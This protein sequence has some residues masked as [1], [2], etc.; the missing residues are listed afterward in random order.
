VRLLGLLYMI[1]G[2]LML[3]AVAYSFVNVATGQADR[4]LADIERQF[5]RQVDPRMREMLTWALDL[6]RA[7]WYMAV[8]HLVPFALG[9]VYVW[10]GSRL[11]ALRGRGPAMAAAIL[12]LVMSPCE[13]QC[14]CCMVAM[15]LGV[16]AL[17]TLTRGDVVTLLRARAG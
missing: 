5:G 6:A 8:N 11:R 10:S 17:V 9:V 3:L 2:G 16:Y 1:L 7:P 15:P 4:A 12:M 14:C 13:G